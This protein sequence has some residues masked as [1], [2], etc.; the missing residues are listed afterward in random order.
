MD[1]VTVVGSALESVWTVY[2]AR[3]WTN[4]YSGERSV[5]INPFGSAFAS[6]D[7]AE[8]FLIEYCADYADLHSADADFSFSIVE[9]VTPPF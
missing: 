3:D 4:P 2:V 1:T 5:F 9:Y 8:H 7:E 6:L